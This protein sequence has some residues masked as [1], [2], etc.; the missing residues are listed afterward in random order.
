MRERHQR[1]RLQDCGAKWRICY[2]DYRSRKRSGRTK[3][4]SKSLVPTRTPAQRL[5]DGFMETVTNE[6]MN[7]NSFL[8]GKKH[9]QVWWQ[10]IGKRCGHCL[11]TQ[12]ASA[13]TIISTPTSCRNGAR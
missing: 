3:S 7:L 1:P 2:W 4:W 6:T 9:S 8:V 12:R 10:F 13:T 11:R 5:A